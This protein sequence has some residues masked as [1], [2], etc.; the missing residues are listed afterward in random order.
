MVGCD[1]ACSGAEMLIAC[2]AVR[3][4]AKVLVLGELGWIDVYGC[5]YHVATL[6]AQ[7]REW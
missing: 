3:I 1:S 6:P 2:L 4:H 7:H 5:G